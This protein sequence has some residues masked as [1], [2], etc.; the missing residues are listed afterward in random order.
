MKKPTI[1][2][3]VDGVLANFIEGVR[4]V[5]G[6]PTLPEP[7]RWSDF[8]PQGSLPENFWE[9]IYTDPWFYDNVPPYPWIDKLLTI[10]HKHAKDIFLLSS[11]AGGA[12]P[13]KANWI[14]RFVCQ[15]IPTVLVSRVSKHNVC[16]DILIDD[17][18]RKCGARGVMTFPQ[19]YNWGYWRDPTELELPKPTLGES[20]MYWL[21][22]AGIPKP[23]E[24]RGQEFVDN[25][26][27]HLLF[28]IERL[29][30][31]PEPL[32]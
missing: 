3:D 21:A 24:V 5:Y 22:Q 19:P 6:T 26:E 1:A 9:D 29:N 15:K 20:N 7:I 31:K 2:I 28:E 14:R 27:D 17:D 11:C 30:N 18:P 4:R 13:G 12:F 32:I 16:W 25:L 8:L 10:A 23:D